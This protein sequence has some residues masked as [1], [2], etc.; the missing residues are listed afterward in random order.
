MKKGTQKRIT[1]NNQ[2]HSIRERELKRDSETKK[3]N[4]QPA[5]AYFTPT[6]VHICAKVIADTF[7]AQSSI[8]DLPEELR[9]LVTEQLSTELPL[10][11]AVQRVQSQEYWCARCEDNWDAGLLADC[12]DKK[13]EV[14]WKRVFLQRSLEEKLMEC[15]NDLPSDA[16]LFEIQQL[17]QLSAASIYSLRLSRLRCHFDLHELFGWLPQLREFSVTYG[18]LNTGIE[19]ELK[20]FGMHDSDATTLRDALRNTTNLHTL[21]LPENRIDDNILKGVLSGLVRNHSVTRVDLSHNTIEDGGA[22]ALATLLMRSE[23]A[24]HIKYLNL[25]DNLIRAQGVADLG[26]ALEVNASL[27]ELLLKLNRLGDEGGK[28]LVE[29]LRTNKSLVMLTLSHNEMGS[30]TAK[31]L[32]D[33]L[34]QNSTLT[35]LDVAGNP[36]L[37]EGGR[38]IREGVEANKTLTDLDLRGCGI[39]E[40]DASAVADFLE[41][42][43]HALRRLVEEKG[44]REANK[45]IEEA[46]VDKMKKLYSH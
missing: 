8:E 15:A 23:P 27:T 42:R 9:Q 45:K 12:V 3:P 4:G 19:F 39:L 44:E 5:A 40:S 28:L 25:S 2:L 36:F 24:Q 16:Q 22:R 35:S 18:V 20:M 26:R 31:A 29:S 14:D 33:V 17:C 11:T 34:R 38:L 7:D 21:R 13:T 43:K 37:E 46:M 10:K 32:S 30:E 1:S 41:N 6:L